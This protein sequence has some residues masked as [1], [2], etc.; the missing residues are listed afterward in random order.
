M[1][2]T[3]QAQGGQKIDV[4]AA[5]LLLINGFTRREMGA[6]EI[7]TFGVKLCDN[8]IDRDGEC[9][10]RETLTEL[11]ELFVGKSGLFDHSWSAKGQAARIY[12][13]EV[14]EESETTTQGGEGYAYLKA[15]AYMVRTEGSAE[16]IAEIEGGIKKEVSVGC[17][18]RGSICSICGA[19]AGDCEHVKGELYDG[20]LCYTRLEGAVDAYEFSFVAVPA[21]PRAGVM[22]SKGPRSLKALCAGKP[23]LKK[24]LEQLEGDAAL[25]R[26]YLLGLKEDVIR[27]GGL[28]NREMDGKILRSLT[29]KMAESE[30]L[31]MKRIYEKQAGE[32]YPIGTQMR[33]GE[34]KEMPVHESAFLI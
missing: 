8:E 28:A 5:D 7:Y 18:V 31:E 23:E 4:T 20:A 34:E 16:L 29:E 26:R 14:I 6:D 10:T 15:Y 27:L 12:R 24:A 17:S 21:Q 22:K 30:L 25:G 19:E 33:Y 9:F 3:K 2:I 1:N 32:K 11:A 13:T